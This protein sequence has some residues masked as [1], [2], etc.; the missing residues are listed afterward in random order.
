MCGELVPPRFR[1]EIT[2]GTSSAHLD[3]VRDKNSPAIFRSDV[4]MIP[5]IGVG[6]S[7]YTDRMFYSSVDR[8][9]GSDIDNFVPFIN[10]SLLHGDPFVI[11]IVPEAG[12]GIIVSDAYDFGLT[13]TYDSPS[14]ADKGDPICVRWIQRPDA[15]HGL[16]LSGR[17]NRQ[18]GTD[19]FISLSAF[20][21]ADL[22]N[23]VFSRGISIP[24]PD[25]VLSGVFN[26]ELCED[27]PYIY[28][29]KYPMNI[30]GVLDSTLPVTCRADS[31]ILHWK[32]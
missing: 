3:S 18:L 12:S 10:Q 26:V 32:R 11:R 23:P 28:G 19:A 25:S 5:F 21:R 14:A 1:I 15:F 30:W 29:Y 27:A 2:I 22:D 9:Q 6:D 7:T 20:Y 8:S 31:L 16:M 24:V 17:F 4:L 13:V